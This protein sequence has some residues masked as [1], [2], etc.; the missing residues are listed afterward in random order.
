M[1]FDPKN[2]EDSPSTNTPINAAAL[3][4]L[5]TRVTNYAD[6]IAGAAGNADLF[7]QEAQP[8]GL[9]RPALWIPLIGDPLEPAPIAQWQVFVP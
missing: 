4:D 6:T 9:T 3:E 5:E 8:V 7:V 1:A 2:W